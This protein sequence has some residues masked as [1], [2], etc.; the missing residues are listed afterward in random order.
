MSEFSMMTQG[1]PSPLAYGPFLVGA[2]L[3]GG[4]TYTALKYFENRHIK[5][6]HA[7]QGR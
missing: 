6:G 2:G 5:T 3:M 4:A 1:I 7:G